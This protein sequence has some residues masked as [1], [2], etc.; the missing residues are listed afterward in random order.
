[1]SSFNTEPLQLDLLQ[2]FDVSTPTP[3]GSTEVEDKAVQLPVARVHID[4]VVPHLDRLFDYRVP[5]ALDADAQPG[6]RVRVKFHGQEVS[7]WL[8]ERTTHSDSP[9]RLLP[10]HK[11]VSPLPVVGPEIFELADALADRY[12]GLVPDVLR[13][14][15]P[16]RV[17]RVE[18]KYLADVSRPEKEDGGAPKA[19]SGQGVGMAASLSEPDALPTPNLSAF[20]DYQ[21]G[22]EFCED[23]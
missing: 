23:L 9:V 2:G 20:D 18:Q 1:M 21:G 12:A 14:A 6:V 7:G 8:R 3:L 13:L 16:L 19:A 11:V 22:R 5:A 15:V 17:A 4:T 10:L